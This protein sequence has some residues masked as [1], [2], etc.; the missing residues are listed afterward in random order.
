[1]VLELQEREANAIVGTDGVTQFRSTTSMKTWPIIDARGEVVAFEVSV[2]AIGLH[3]IA[4]LLNSLP[5]VSQSKGRSSFS[6]EEVHMNFTYQG[7]NCVVWEPFGD[8]SRYWI[9]PADE[10]DKQAHDM[11]EIETAFRSYK[12]SLL[13]RI[14]CP[15]KSL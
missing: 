1:M 11:A 10:A 13:K 14:F 2:I 4:K 9:G 5:G 12:P 7:T 8:N 6:G 15:S 3:Q